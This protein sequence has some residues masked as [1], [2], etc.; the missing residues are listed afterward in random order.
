MLIGKGDFEVELTM[1]DLAGQLEYAA[2]LQPYIVPGS[3]YLLA[4]PAHLACDTNYEPL[5]GRWLDALQ[6]GAPNAVVLAVLTQCDRLKG[7]LLYTSDAAD[8]M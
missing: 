1:W 6:A 8:D 4:V 5:L 7:C 2:S 3:L